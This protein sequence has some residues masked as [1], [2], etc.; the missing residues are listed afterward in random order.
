MESNLQET[1]YDQLSSIYNKTK[2]RQQ[3]DPEGFRPNDKR[4]CCEMAA[5]D[6]LNSTQFTIT[7]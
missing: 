7:T 1:K 2:K 3:A 4:A 5:S 6:Y